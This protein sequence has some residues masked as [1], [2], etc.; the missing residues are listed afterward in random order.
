MSVYHG[1]AVHA[2]ARGHQD[3][4]NWSDRPLFCLIFVPGTAH[5]YSTRT[6]RF[7]SV[8]PFPWLLYLIIRQPPSPNLELTALASLACIGVPR[9]GLYLRQ[10]PVFI[11]ATMPGFLCGCCEGLDFGTPGCIGFTP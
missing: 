11:H 9:T 3:L 5:C 7:L 1:P 10:E 2:V 4:Q 8:K 6:A